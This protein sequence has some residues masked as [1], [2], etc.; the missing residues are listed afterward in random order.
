MRTWRSMKTLSVV[1]GDAHTRCRVER[2]GLRTEPYQIPTSWDSTGEESDWENPENAEQLRFPEN[3]SLG[4]RPVCTEN[5]TSWGTAIPHGGMD[6]SWSLL[7]ILIQGPCCPSGTSNAHP[8][9][10]STLGE[11]KEILAFL[12]HSDILGVA[13]MIFNI[14]ICFIIALSSK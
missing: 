13:V 7:S 3:Q 6:L 1:D 9:F 14:L 12:T 10:L 4:D 8:L 2:S 11:D 5:F